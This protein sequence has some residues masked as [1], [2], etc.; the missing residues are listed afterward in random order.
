MKRGKGLHRKTPLRTTKPLKAKRISIA[1]GKTTTNPRKPKRPATQPG[2]TETRAIVR[3]RSGGWCEVA[4]PGVC[5]GRAT[6]YQHRVNRSQG[7]KYTPSAA[8]DACG[9]GTTGCH[10]AIHASPARAYENGW[11]VRSTDHPLTRP[12]LR[13]GEWVLLDDAGGYTPALNLGAA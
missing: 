8:L 3:A 13:R 11:S 10:G 4:I 6:N 12:V 2:E 9:S 7:G 1:P 5:L